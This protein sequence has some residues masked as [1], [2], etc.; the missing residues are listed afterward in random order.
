[1]SRAPAA[2]LWAHAQRLAF[3][4]LFLAALALA[5]FLSREHSLAVDWTASG[6]NTLSQASR[7]LL[8]RLPG[9]IHVRAFVSSDDRLREAV[10]QLLGRYQ[11]AHPQVSLE[12]ISPEREPRESERFGVQREGELVVE[13]GGRRE[14]VQGL[15]EALLSNALARLARGPGRWIAFV[16]GHGER[17]M[18]GEARRDLGLFARHLESLG[19]RLRPL[20]L[21]S[22]PQVPENVSLLV[23]LQPQSAWSAPELRALDEYLDRGG[24]LLWLADPGSEHLGTL[25][26]RLGVHVEPGM[27]VDPSSRLQGQSTPEFV[28][29]R[30]YASHPVTDGLNDCSR[31]RQ[32]PGHRRP[33]RL[34]RVSH[35]H[36]PGVGGRGGLAR[37]GHRRERAA[38]LARDR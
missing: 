34:H 27:L 22:T 2:V 30:G 19:L 24:N 31:L 12:F 15:S 37:P 33:E 38:H 8:S 1:V 4:L 18:L 32:P 21:A 25:A 14:N 11:R 3:T 7:E 20:P 9:N 36:Q 10:R 28:L 16:T 5:A 13:Y 26:Q 17:D 29:V 35:R 23:V 6:R